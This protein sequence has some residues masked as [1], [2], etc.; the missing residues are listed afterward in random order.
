[1]TRRALCLALVLAGAVTAGAQAPEAPRK[2]TLH[3]AAAPTPALKYVLLP[4]LADMQPG[5][6]ALLYQRAHNFEWWTNLRRQPHYFEI[7]DWLDRPLKEVRDKIPLGR[8]FIALK[9]V[10]IAARRESCDWEM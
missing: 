2:L 6:A 10:D 1:M 3:P 5:N 9:E 8:D 4:D 7:G